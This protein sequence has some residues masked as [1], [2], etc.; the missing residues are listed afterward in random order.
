MNYEYYTR[1][2]IEIEDSGCEDLDSLKHHTIKIES[3][4]SDYTIHSWFA[5]FERVLRLQGFNDEVI[6]R[7]GCQVAF[8]KTRSVEL[9]RKIAYSYNLKLLEDEDED[10]D[11][12]QSIPIVV[13]SD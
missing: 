4:M 8:N 9:M 1:I 3:E 6:A 2:K 5:L 11:I 12:Q 7:G 13:I 10:E